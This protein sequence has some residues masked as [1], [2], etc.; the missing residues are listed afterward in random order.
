MSIKYLIIGSIL[1][2]IFVQCQENKDSSKNYSNSTSEVNSTRAEKLKELVPKLL[3]VDSLIEKRNEDY[4]PNYSNWRKGNFLLLSFVSNQDI[5]LFNGNYA[6]GIYFKPLIDGHI[7]RSII[8][9]KYPWMDTE[10]ELKK[11]E[12]YFIIVNGLASTSNCKTTLWIG[13]EGKN[14]L[15]NNLPYYSVIGKIGDGAP[16]FIG[17]K[18]E[19]TPKENGILYLGYNDDLY[20]ENIGYYVADIFNMPEEVTMAR[21]KVNEISIGSYYAE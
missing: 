3:E 8:N 9:I 11:G 10:I 5:N 6:R 1:G 15:Y 7:S 13:P 12:T 17:K 14:H 2:L 4:S 16:F 18:I 20:V 21:L 19:I